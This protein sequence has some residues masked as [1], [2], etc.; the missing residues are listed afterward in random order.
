MFFVCWVGGEKTSGQFSKLWVARSPIDGPQDSKPPGSAAAIKLLV[1]AT[2][3]FPI[4]VNYKKISTQI[5]V[6]K[7]TC[8]K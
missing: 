5:M 3:S 1:E 2:K 6:S 4:L 8:R 7:S